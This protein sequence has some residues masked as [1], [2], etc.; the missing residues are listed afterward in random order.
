MKIVR[1]AAK[2]VTGFGVL[3][4]GVV[5]EIKG[6]PWGKLDL[7]GRCFPLGGVRLLA[8]VQPPDVFAIGLNYKAHAD[9]SGFKHPQAP[10]I[11]LKAASSVIG[12]EDAIVLPAMAPS[13][14]DYEAEMAIVIGRTCRSIAEEEALDYVLGYTCGN[15]VSARDCQLKQDQQWARG[16]SFETFCPLGPWI[17]T[18]IDPDAQEIKLL[19]NGEVMQHSN[20]DDLIFSCRQLVS[21]CSRIVTLR[22]GTVILT[23]TPA[24][25]GFTRK[26]PVFLKAGDTVEVS[27]AGIG[28]LT[29]K[30][31][32]ESGMQE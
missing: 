22:P 24:G 18:D 3:E 25:V 9:E 2:D 16:K 15:D 23:G 20:T 4:D 17:E 5:K 12:P 31:R 30:V 10:V 1:F 13:E 11:F 8:P 14:V 29:N 7:T 26:P 21:Y 28:T 32:E 6:L 27:I 19:L